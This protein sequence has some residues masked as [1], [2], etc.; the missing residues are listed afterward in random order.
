MSLNK[1][2]KEQIG[3]EKKVVSKVINKVITRT[4]TKKIY[5]KTITHKCVEYNNKK[6]IVGYTIFKGTDKLFV[7][8]DDKK[9]KVIN[10]QWKF[11][12]NGGYISHTYFEDK[13]RTTKRNLGL[14]NLVMNRLS[15][16]GKGQHHTVDHINRIGRDNRCENLRI[17]TQ[18]HQNINQAKRE[19]TI[20][21]PE[22]CDIDPQTIP[23]NIYYRK[24]S[25]AH[26]ERFS[27]D[28]KLGDGNRIR[29][30]TTKSKS[31]DLK[32]KL[33]FAILKLEEIKKTYPELQEIKD[34]DDIDKRNELTKS[35]NEILKIS[36]YPA[37]IINENLV[38]CE[39]LDETEFNED[40]K[41]TAKKL[42]EVG[43]RGLKCKLPQD[44]GITHKMIPKYCY[45]VPESE[46]RG[47][48]FVIDRHPKLVENGDRQWSTTARKTISTKDKYTALIE[49]LTDMG[50]VFED[51]SEYKFEVFNLKGES[52]GKFKVKDD[53]IKF[54]I[55]KMNIKSLKSTVQD[56]I[57]NALKKGGFAYT[58][59]YKLID[60]NDETEENID[61]I[62]NDDS[63]ENI[64]LINTEETEE[65][66]IE[67]EPDL[68]DYN[69]DN[70]IEE[71]QNVLSNNL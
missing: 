12:S 54:M 59:K 38:D 13:E 58:H 24:A 14:H 70:E 5:Q 9:D 44:C 16:N 28:I 20:E 49:K 52:A 23:K 7:F 43:T 33:K 32:T 39:K 40:E 55:D 34:I 66:E 62:N 60:H 63:E 51:N 11:D 18:T 45:Y 36:G 25:G 41:K 29:V 42:L 56:Q 64:N 26:G 57:N 31:I 8:D 27:I 61:I 69:T 65:Y 1:N 22:G 53:M 15:F 3:E 2:V 71:N 4:I 10:R 37:R 17:L 46:T 50:D 68:V 21:L 30:E 35:F 19:R 67:Y 6:Y 47:D 48:K